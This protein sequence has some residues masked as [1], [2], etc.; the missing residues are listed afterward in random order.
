MFS[1][2]TIQINDRSYKEWSIE[3]PISNV[4]PLESK[5]FH[6]DQIRMTHDKMIIHISP[7]RESS[8]IPGI[9]ILENN[10]TYG[11]TE[12]KK[13]LFYK[14][15]PFNPNYPDFLVPYIIPMGFNKNFQNKYVTFTF[16]RWNQED[17]HPFG[18]LS[19]TIGE[20]HNLP[21]FYEYQLYC[22]HLHTPITPLIKYCKDKLKYCDKNT[23][24]NIIES[25]P[26]VYGSIHSKVPTIDSTPF[27]KEYIFTVDPP[28]CKDRDDAISI[29][30]DTN[31]QLFYDHFIL[32]VHIANVWLWAEVLD[33]WSLLGTRASTVYLPDTKRSMLPSLISEELC[34]LD[35]DKECYAFTMDFTVIRTKDTTT[36]QPNPILYQSKIKVVHNYDYEETD[37]CKNQ[38]YKLIKQ[39]TVQ[40]DSNVK[41]SHDVIAFWMMQMNKQ[42]AEIMWNNQF[43][44]YRS[45]QISTSSP[46]P[47]PPPPSS[48]PIND[49]S[50]QQLPPDV[51]TF[52]QL[53]EHKLQG[54]YIK[55]SEA[56][57]TNVYHEML[58]TKYY[59]HATSPIRRLVD[60]V[61]Q[62]MCVHYLFQPL[63][64][65]EEP[66]QFAQDQ[67]NKINEINDNMKRIR[68][69]QN[70]CDI[71]AK[72][73]NEPEL[74]DKTL[75]A[76]VL[77]KTPNEPKYTIYIP[78]V[79]WTTTMYCI[80]TETLQ[81]YQ[82]IQC[83]LYVFEREDQMRRKVRVEFKYTLNL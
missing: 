59:T 83:K 26:D 79:K 20:V 70:N 38:F 65:R 64:M 56:N 82:Q 46:M 52:L 55:F 3:P 53:W 13:R 33:L 62:V 29:K 16:D 4:Q 15:R 69:V 57:E 24:M 76:I 37:L 28:G 71:L 19:Q 40:L 2:H 17:K 45:V 12:N 6:Q 72:V 5:L 11:R 58:K 1:I 67:L 42:I 74:T 48:P 77:A 50:K 81:K 10:R 63:H 68:K 31:P 36:I 21:A 9:L 35:T 7:L 44:I 23:W 51:K 41:D 25:S 14:C 75:L 30:R 47:P 43:G 34:S 54:K 22:Y 39:L 32:S 8:N 61:N 66:K 73:T 78:D 18:I 80:E 27:S 49:S 60:F